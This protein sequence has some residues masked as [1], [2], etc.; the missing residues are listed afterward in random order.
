MR[1][2]YRGRPADRVCVLPGN[3][4]MTATPSIVV[5]LAVT[6]PEWRTIQKIAI[7]RGE[8]PSETMA[9]VIRKHLLTATKGENNGTAE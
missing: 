1:F 8:R 4:R 3:C 9:G 6:D 7:D 2:S 5:R